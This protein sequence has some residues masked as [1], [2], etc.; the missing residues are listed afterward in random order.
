MSKIR[1]KNTRPELFIRSEL[2]KRKHRFRVNYSIVEGRPDIYFSR[3]KVAVFVHGCYWHRHGGCKFAYTPKSNN[4]F[5]LSKFSANQKRDGIV[6][7]ALL[8]S[9]IRVLVIWECSIKKM[10]NN[11]CIYNE[12]MSRIENFIFRENQ[13][14]LE[15]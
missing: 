4:E 15:I 12:M 7:E 10:K 13:C 9:G 1:S 3:I 5:W 6:N 8:N 11:T 2:F 14:Y